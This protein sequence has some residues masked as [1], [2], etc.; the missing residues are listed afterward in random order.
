MN[1]DL[2][3]GKGDKMEADNLKKLANLDIIGLQSMKVVTS[4]NVS[5]STRKSRRKGSGQ[6]H[7]FHNGKPTK[8]KPKA[9]ARAARTR[10][11]KM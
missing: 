9:K 1:L 10:M 3:C 2:V 6:N 4:T 5:Q 7:N 11:L 8:A